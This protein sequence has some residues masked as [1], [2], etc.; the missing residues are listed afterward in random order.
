MRVKCHAQE[1]NTMT[2]PGLEP[3]LLDPE[4]STLSKSPC[5]PLQADVEICKTKAYLVYDAITLEM[6]NTRVNALNVNLFSLVRRFLWITHVNAYGI[7]S[8]IFR[9]GVSRTH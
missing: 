7:F 3:R 1:H 6:K 4:S 9:I 5:L 2:R 8:R